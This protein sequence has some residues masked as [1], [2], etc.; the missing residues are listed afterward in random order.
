MYIINRVHYIEAPQ[1]CS[2]NIPQVSILLKLSQQVTEMVVQ[3]KS[4]QYKIS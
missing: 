3:N 1:F 2:I 4:S